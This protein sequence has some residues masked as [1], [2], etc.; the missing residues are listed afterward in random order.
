MCQGKLKKATIMPSRSRRLSRLTRVVILTLIL[1]STTWTAG[2]REKLATI[3]ID[4]GHGGGDYGNSGPA[5]LV[6]KDITLAVAKLIVKERKGTYRV[7]LTRTGDYGLSL[8]ERTAAANHQ[9]ADLFI[10]LHAGG[11]TSKQKAGCTI[12]YFKPA[13]PGE[14]LSSSHLPDPESLQDTPTLWSNCQAVHISKSRAA[15]EAIASRFSKPFISTGSPLK[16]TIQ[17]YPLIVLSGADM[18]ALLMEIGYLTNP[19]EEKNLSTNEYLSE[20]ANR[21]CQGIDE[22]FLKKE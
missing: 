3:V 7:V 13:S 21:I 2:A 20:I 9:R 1:V 10:S 15:A 8:F 11:S 14:A 19:G 5:R 22:F 4:P 18:P 6:E 16:T 17:G 12:Y